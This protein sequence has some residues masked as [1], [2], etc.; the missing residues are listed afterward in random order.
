MYVLDPVHYY[1]AVESADDVMQKIQLANPDTPLPATPTSGPTGRIIIP[2]SYASDGLGSDDSGT[3]RGNGAAKGGSILN[4]LVGRVLWVGPG[5]NWEGA[6]VVPQCK[7]GDLLLFS[8]RVVSHEL[9]LHGRSIKIVPWSEVISKV[10]EVSADSEEARELRREV[11][12]S[13]QGPSSDAPA[14]DVQPEAV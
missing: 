9:R 7:R 13:R 8:P 10:R 1:V 12:L 2:D 4:L 3:R 14:A 11:P 6:F 5:K